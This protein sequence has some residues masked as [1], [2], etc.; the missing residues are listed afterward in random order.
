VT[1]VDLLT[2]GEAMISLRSTGPLAQ[3]GSLTTHMAGSEANV[4]IAMSR[5]GH[6]TRWVGRVGRDPHGEFIRRQLRAE[7][8]DEWVTVDPGRSTGLMFLEQRTAD[9]SR[10]LYYR[11][12]SAG[13]AVGFA[14]VEPA[15]KSSAKVLHLTGIT[16]AL[17]PQARDAFERAAA[18][19]KAH[20]MALSLDVNYRNKLWSRQEAAEVLSAV[21]RHAKI[22]V[23]SED[24][25]DLLSSR[26]TG[27][28]KPAD[29]PA[30]AA[31]LLALGV[32]EVVV[33]LGSDGAQVHTASNTFHVDAV[34]VNAVDTVGAGDAFTA[35]YLSAL[36]DGQSIE[37]RLRRGNLMGAFAVSTRGDWEGLPN[38]AELDLLSTQAAG[39][40]QR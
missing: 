19:A 8:V 25:L 29:I 13:S 32:E 39:S 34:P 5:L 38:R 17:S 40:T 21:A 4:A 1:T 31:E 11:K 2:F 27:I 9:I 37:E 23:A 22:V 26:R 24:E 16:P 20:G 30:V 18:S 33:K 15:L 12:G 7:S 35:G 28:S 3:G 36:L 6:A 14:D 10:A